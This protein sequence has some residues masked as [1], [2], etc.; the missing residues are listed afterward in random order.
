[1]AAEKNST[2]VVPFPVELLRFLEK[3][4]DR[5]VVPP[6]AKTTT[7]PV[8]EG[9]RDDAFALEPRENTENGDGDR[10]E[11]GRIAGH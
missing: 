1:V 7:E 6:P 4:T 8:P 9:S 10:K 2:L 11:P 3:S 5:P